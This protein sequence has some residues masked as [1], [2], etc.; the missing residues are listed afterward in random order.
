[1]LVGKPR[2]VGIGNGSADL[3][4]FQGSSLALLIPTEHLKD[5]LVSRAILGYWGSSGGDGD[6]R[7][8]QWP[9]CLGPTRRLPATWDLRLGA[10]ETGSLDAA[11]AT[12]GSWSR[13]LG[14]EDRI[15][16]RRH[17]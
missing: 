12:S 7:G 8:R 17:S 15:G 14:L 9:C 13:V 11:L 3:T 5:D 1:M 16:T 10:A 4:W 6:Q 2:V